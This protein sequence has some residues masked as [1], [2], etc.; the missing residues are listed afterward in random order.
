M[1]R[2]LYQL[3]CENCAKDFESTEPYAK[4][5]SAACRQQM[6]RRRQGRTHGS[7]IEM[8]SHTSLMLM[9][10]G[11]LD[12][13]GYTVL[14]PLH[15][16]ILNYDMMA[17]KQGK[18]IRIKVVAPFYDPINTNWRACVGHPKTHHS[19][20][21]LIS[22]SKG[23]FF[24]F[25]VDTLGY[26]DERFRI[27]LNTTRTVVESKTDPIQFRSAWNLLTDSFKSTY[28]YDR[29]ETVPALQD[30]NV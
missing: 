25:P 28:E 14:V 16:T 5:H 13:L 19:F 18:T 3:V 10:Y 30:S 2:K 9:V 24:I 17:E 7:S 20:D 22:V 6:H 27:T 15:G 23:E 8:R 1:R 21:V 4:F 12:K 29:G 26:C 11:A